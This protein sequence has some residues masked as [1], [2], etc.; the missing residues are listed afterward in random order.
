M[1]KYKFDH[2]GVMI[3]CSRNS[4][5]SLDGLRRLLPLLKKMG[6]NTVM[7][8][9]EDTYEVDGEPYFGYMRG[10]YS[11]EEMK[12]ID[13]FAQSLGIE[14]IPC[15]QTLAHLNATLRWNKIPVDTA[16]I[17]L[18]D[19][20]RTYELIDRMFRTLSECFHSRNIHIGMDEAHM[21]GRGRHL[22]LHGYET[23]NDCIKRHLAKVCEIAAKYDYKPQ[24]WSDMFFRSWNNGQYYIPECKMPKEI[25]DSVP[26][27]VTLA[28]WD[29]YHAKYEDYDAMIKNHRQFGCPVW[30]AGGVWTWTGVTPRNAFSIK[31]MVPAI[32]ACKANKIRNV[33]FTMWG[34]DGGECSRFSVLPALF[35]LSQ[36]AHGETDE[37]VIKEKFKRFTGIAFDNFM[38]IELSDSLPSKH[39]YPNPSKYMFMSDLLNDYLDSTVALGNG[40]KYAAWS[41]ELADVAK[42]SRTYGYL[43][44]TQAKLCAVLANKYELGLRTRR[45]YEAGDKEELRR[46]AENEYVAVEKAIPAF[47]DAMEKQWFKENK[48]CG[49][50]VQEWRI[51]GVLQRVKSARKRILD[52]VNGRIDRIEELEEKLLP[53]AGEEGLATCMNQCRLYA[54]TNVLSH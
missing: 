43:F 30:F 4:V 45:A 31:S 35:Y 21:L 26:E 14:M 34:D 13:A 19:D 25:T 40:E 47:R 36:Y 16:D 49:F 9:T 33:Y 32:D 54:T 2:F 8:Y 12:E 52:Y 53:F 6:Y 29:Y 10:R 51:G 41:K 7:L 28:Y 24:I 50:D 22:D 48:T 42:K 5:M 27:N 38:K 46:L 3:D 11:K 15:I 17:M 23:A 20:P 1:S 39:N 37:A 44:D 18:T